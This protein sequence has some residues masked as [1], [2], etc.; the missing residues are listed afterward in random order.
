MAIVAQS[1]IARPLPRADAVAMAAAR[2]LLQADLARL[3]RRYTDLAN[4]VRAHDETIECFGDYSPQGTAAFHAGQRLAAEME[5][6][7]FDMDALKAAIR[8]LTPEEAAA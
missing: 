8:G 3:R 6:L 2:L 1:T 5:T 7:D 4:Q